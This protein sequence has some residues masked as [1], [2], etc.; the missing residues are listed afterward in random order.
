MGHKPYNRIRSFFICY[1]FNGTENTL[2]NHRKSTSIVENFVV[3]L[4]DY[5]TDGTTKI[6]ITSTVNTTTPSL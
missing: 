3:Y 1:P 4:G 5:Y 6:S 2:R